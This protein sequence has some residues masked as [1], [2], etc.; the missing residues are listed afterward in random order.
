M[1]FERKYTKKQILEMY[2]NEVFFG[3]GAWGIT[4]ASQLYFDKNPEELNE[5]EC[6]LL[7]GVPKAPSRYN[8][9][10]VASK[11]RDRRNLVLQRMLELKMIP[12]PQWEKLRNHPISII[13]PGEAPYYLTHLR[14]KLIE[15][16]GPALIEQGGLEI[17]TA[18]D[19]PLQKLAEKV[20][21]DGV[22]QISPQLQ[23]A[24][25]CLD[26]NTGDVLAAVGGVDFT[27]NPY[28]R[29]YNARRQPGSAIKPLIY[30][31][32]LE[33]GITPSSL[34]NDTPVAYNKGNHEIWKPLNYERKLYGELT[35]RQ[36]LAYSNNIITVKLLDTIGVP[37]FVNFARTL[38]LPLRS[39]NDL[40]LALGT[41]EV[42]LNDL[43]LTYSPL[44]NGG[45]RPEARTIIR[46]FDRNHNSWLEN[47]PIVNPVL[48][49]ATAFVTTQMLKD[50]LIYGTAKS[51][52]AFSQERP[53]AGKT[54]TT[55]DFRDAWFIGY[56]PQIITGVWVGYDKPKPGGRGFTGGAVCAPI[57][58]RF[59]RSALADK[60]V[61]DFPQPEKVVSASID[62]TTGFL[63]TQNCP[64]KQEE[65]Y[66]E[67]TQPTE[68]CP[69]H[70]M[71][72]WKPVPLQTP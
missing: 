8:P 4:Q 42:T 66:I 39:P 54:G 6:A 38:G 58:A 36:A 37:Y 53:A 27:Q 14:N 17:T 70:P 41:E 59:M 72:N 64:I 35:L 62:P 40:S 34:W 33:K 45:F 60:P 69:K 49:P 3:N 31:A 19:L 55:D 63:A 25:I 57:W 47:T 65:F 26:P 24:L 52:H 21:S 71:E 11:I 29:A 30:A 61:M 12:R 5:A 28:N 16:Y 67:G 2:F 56:T 20:L 23:G 22:R 43:I 9:L 48:S 50:V 10:G 51:I 7:A 1:E 13:K 46:I 18:M 15:R 44:A 68:Y 32:A